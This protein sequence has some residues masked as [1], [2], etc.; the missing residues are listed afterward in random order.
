MIGT[1]DVLQALF[2]AWTAE[3]LDA[4]FQALR[5]A[6]SPASPSLYDKTGAPGGAFPYAV[7]ELNTRVLGRMSAEAGRKRETREYML[8]LRVHA[9]TIDG[10][11]RSARKL[12]YELAELVTATLG[13]HPTAP[14]VALA[15]A[16]GNHI[17]TQ[18][19][20]DRPEETEL[21]RAAWVIEYRLLADVP[22][23]VAT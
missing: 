23:A 5:P 3:G 18:Y 12:A 14:P 19:V 22:V 11:P 9:K 16:N 10:D 2:A 1:A 7:A 4:A 13:G 15:L 21:Y 6:G 17:L 20:N 8:S